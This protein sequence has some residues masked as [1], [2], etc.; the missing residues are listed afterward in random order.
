MLTRTYLASIRAPFRPDLTIPVI[1]DL[2]LVPGL[3][4]CVTWAL[5]LHAGHLH[6]IATCARGFPKS[7]EVQAAVQEPASHA[8]STSQTAAT[9]VQGSVPPRPRGGIHAKTPFLR[10]D[11]PRRG[12]AAGPPI[13]AAEYATAAAASATS[14]VTATKKLNLC[15][16]IND[17]L[18]VAL[19]SDIK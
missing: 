15:N 6:G 13:A 18:N 7:R 4:S 1:S 5:A 19:E 16:A 11:S 2:S 8:P 9:V 14:P 10:W 17:A 3:P 12:G